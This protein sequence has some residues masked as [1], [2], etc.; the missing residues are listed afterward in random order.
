MG[1]DLRES[2]EAASLKTGGNTELIF[3]L[4]GQPFRAVVSLYDDDKNLAIIC[5]E[6]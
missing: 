1:L 3:A 4:N 6:N 2:R 5:I